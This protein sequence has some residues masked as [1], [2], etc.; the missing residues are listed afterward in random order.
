MIS[1][2]VEVFE[3]DFTYTQEIKDLA[4]DCC[5]DIQTATAPDGVTYNSNGGLCSSES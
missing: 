2:S 4:A 3:D 5:A 1:Q